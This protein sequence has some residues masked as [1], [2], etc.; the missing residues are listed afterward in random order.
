VIRKLE[1]AVQ[2]AS[3]TQQVKERLATAGGEEAFLDQAEF[4]QFLKTDAVRWERVVKA[5]KK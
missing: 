5:I 2:S 4:T 1:K 3:A